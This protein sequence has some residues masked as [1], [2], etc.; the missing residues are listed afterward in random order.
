M[1]EANW[2]VGGRRDKRRERFEG[3]EM[4]ST[5]DDELDSTSQAAPDAGGE[6][7]FICSGKPLDHNEKGKSRGTSFVCAVRLAMIRCD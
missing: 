7:S 4:R 2:G 1:V 3:R 5:M 6:R